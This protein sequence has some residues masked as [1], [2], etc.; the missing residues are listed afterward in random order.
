MS[1]EAKLE[2]LLEAVDKASAIFKTA[3]D[4][5]QGAMGKVETAQTKPFRRIRE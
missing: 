2:I 5:I 4:N 3:S 1:V